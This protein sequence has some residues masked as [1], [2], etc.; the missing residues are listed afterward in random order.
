MKQFSVVITALFII[1]C[2]TSPTGQRQLLLFPESQ[3]ADMGAAAY[4]QMKTEIPS[5]Q[6]GKQRRYVNCVADAVTAVVPGATPW[7]VW[8]VT[9]FDSDEINA[10]ALPGGKIGVYTGLLKAANS[11]D[12]LAAVVGHEIA[13]VTARHGNARVSATYATQAGLQIAQ[14][15]GGSASSEKRQLLA[16]LGLG[17][18]YGVLMP[19]G[20]G[21]ESEADVIGLEY[22]AMAG[23]DPRQSVEVWRNMS[24][25]SGGAQPPTLLSTHPTHENRISGL[26]AH[27]KTAMKLYKRARKS[28]L[29]P[30][31][32]Q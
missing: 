9:V 17:A 31:C 13:H 12:R 21:Q 6:D 19:Y 18:Q 27:M 22:M 10:F 15:L 24:E 5:T 30:A 26:N 20:R 11:P 25:L 8:E 3:M 29:K 23:F 1:G 32:K 4:T 16:L 14:V 28:G 7:E 2:S